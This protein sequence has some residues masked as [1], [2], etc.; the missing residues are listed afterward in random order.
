MHRMAKATK[1][2]AKKGIK[3]VKSTAP[4]EETAPAVADQVETPAAGEDRVPTGPEF[5]A[6]SLELLNDALQKFELAVAALND[7]GELGYF[8][9]LKPD[10]FCA[11]RRKAIGKYVKDSAFALSSLRDEVQIMINGATAVERADQKVERAKRIFPE[12]NVPAPDV[13]K[14]ILLAADA[15]LDA[16]ALEQIVGHYDLT[17]AALAE[18]QFG[19]AAAEQLLRAQKFQVQCRDKAKA[20]HAQKT[21]QA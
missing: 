20:L 21:A 1:K 3:V 17:L 8:K 11:E 7:A 16:A 19:G 14:P 10:D 2:A 9:D 5:V 4:V 18:G 12:F 15:E 6:G 13:P